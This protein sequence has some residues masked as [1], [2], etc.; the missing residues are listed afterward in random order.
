MVS[1]KRTGGV[2]GFDLG[3][4]GLSSGCIAG[5]AGGLGF[6]SVGLPWGPASGQA[7]SSVLTLVLPDCPAAALPVGLAVWVFRL[8]VCRGLRQTD[9]R[10]RMEPVRGAAAE[11][12]TK[13]VA[14]A[15]AVVGGSGSVSESGSAGSRSGTGSDRES[16]SGEYSELLW[17]YLVGMGALRGEPPQRG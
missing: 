14:G 16:C 7:V 8:S 4:A 17:S 5:R 10:C 3:S 2:A 15:G 11:A 1:G 13:A 6:P 12:E 9:R